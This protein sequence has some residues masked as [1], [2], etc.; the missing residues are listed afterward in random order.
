MLKYDLSET[1]LNSKVKESELAE[2]IK[3][4]LEEEMRLFYNLGMREKVNQLKPSYEMLVNN[5]D[6]LRLTPK[7][8]RD[9]VKTVLDQMKAPMA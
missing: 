1:R 7:E 9:L 2:R 6:N 5:V 4:I 8:F 3:P